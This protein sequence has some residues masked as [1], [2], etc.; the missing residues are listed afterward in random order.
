MITAWDFETNQYIVSP[1]SR[2]EK[3]VSPTLTYTSNGILMPE[4]QK[5]SYTF[6][7]YWKDGLE[8]LFWVEEG[9]PLEDY[10][11]E[12]TCFFESFSGH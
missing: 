3:Y 11:D 8:Y 6:E 9:A 4:I 10:D 12:I 1:D 5:K 2:L 7:T